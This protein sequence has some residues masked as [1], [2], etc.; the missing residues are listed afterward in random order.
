[1]HA[2]IFMSVTNVKQN[3]NQNPG[4]VV[5]FVLMVLSRAHLSK[6]EKIVV[7]KNYADEKNNI[8]VSH[9]A[10]SQNKFW[11]GGFAA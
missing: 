8:A 9:Y 11:A 7:P 4:I 3:L 5:S 1:M 2:S 10:F 6:K